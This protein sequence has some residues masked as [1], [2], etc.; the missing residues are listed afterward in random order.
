MKPTVGRI[1]HVVLI[2]AYQNIVVR[3]GIVTTVYAPGTGDQQINATV[4][5]E[6]DDGAASVV[7]M[8]GLIYD[9]SGAHPGGWHWPPRES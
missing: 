2:N 1:V 7:P 9:A 4:F 6:T 8:T 3:P 5:M